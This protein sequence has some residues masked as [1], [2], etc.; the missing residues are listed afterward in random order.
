MGKVELFNR[1]SNIIYTGIL[2]RLVLG[3]LILFSA[4]ISNE[5]HIPVNFKIETTIDIL[6]ITLFLLLPLFALYSIVREYFIYVLKSIVFDHATKELVIKEF[7]L[8]KEN[9]EFKLSIDDVEIFLKGRPIGGLYFFSSKL[10]LFSG[11][12][13]QLFI[14]SYRTGLTNKKICILYDNLI[15]LKTQNKR[16]LIKS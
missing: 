11:D 12:K 10:T 14:T 7:N 4:I 15:E 8:F 5:S 2:L 1:N 9:K 13:K 16:T 3:F 6:N